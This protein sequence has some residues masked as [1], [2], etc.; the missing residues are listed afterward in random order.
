MKPEDI[1][2]M[3][4]MPDIDAEWRRFERDVIDAP[5]LARTSRPW[6]GRAAAIALVCVVS[7]LALAATWYL[8]HKPVATDA[9]TITSIPEQ[10]APTE[11]CE[12]E[13]EEIELLA[14]WDETAGMYVFDNQELQLI[15]EALSMMYPV[16]PVFVNEE[17]RHIRLYFSIVPQERSIEE[18]VALLNTF[19]HVRLR[20]EDGKLLIE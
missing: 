5:R 9:P 13:P 3:I 10:P 11:D 1:D 18:I 6:M 4:G 2:R 7:S 14:C 15:A 12:L 20:L 17:A 8:W 19:H 16:E